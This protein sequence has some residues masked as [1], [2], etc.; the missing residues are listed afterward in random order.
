MALACFDS[1]S[2]WR[3]YR[4]SWYNSMLSGHKVISGTEQVFPEVLGTYEDQLGLDYE[5][6]HVYVQEAPRI[7][8]VLENGVLYPS[9]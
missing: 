5:S 7:F 2:L 1:G 3:L 9:L 4:L 8:P 6:A